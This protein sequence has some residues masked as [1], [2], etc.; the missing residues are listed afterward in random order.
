[1]KEDIEDLKETILRITLEKPHT[2]GCYWFLY[3]EYLLD[4]KLAFTSTK[5][6]Y[7]VPFKHIKEMP[8]TESIS[9]T[10]R[11]LCEDHPEIRPD[12]K[13]QEYRMMNE[14]EMDHINEWWEPTVSSI[15]KQARLVE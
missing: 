8:S 4:Q 13:V 3:F 1:M 5:G 11:K 12:E 9:R 15:P 7:Y 10:Y 2:R 14:Y 6:G